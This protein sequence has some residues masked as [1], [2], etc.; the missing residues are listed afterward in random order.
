MHLWWVSSSSQPILPWILIEPHVPFFHVGKCSDENICS[1]HHWPAFDY[2]GRNLWVQK[3][4]FKDILQPKSSNKANI[5]H[6]NPCSFWSNHF[7][8]R[9]LTLE[10]HILNLFFFT[11]KKFL[12]L[13]VS[14]KLFN[15]RLSFKSKT[16]NWNSTFR[17]TEICLPYLL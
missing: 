2:Q 5:S 8:G 6:P 14:E 4:D 1:V 15:M 17:S 11:L 12:I 16:T 7:L 10:E 9:L 13:G 3:V